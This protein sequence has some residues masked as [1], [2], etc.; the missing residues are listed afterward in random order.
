MNYNIQQ[1]L[2]KN[3][4]LNARNECQD[5]F[6]MQELIRKLK[7]RIQNREICERMK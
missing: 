1:L 3:K 4:D 7:I 2:R 5:K 6:H